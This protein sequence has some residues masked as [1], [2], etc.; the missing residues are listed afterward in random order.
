MS[1][2]PVV[3]EVKEKP[4]HSGSKANAPAKKDGGSAS[5]GTDA[6]CRWNFMAKTRHF[7]V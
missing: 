5:T 3:P 6:V 7:F 2:V 4:K 1:D